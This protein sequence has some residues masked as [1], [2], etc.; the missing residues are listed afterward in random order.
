VRAISNTGQMSMTG[1]QHR[2]RAVVVFATFAFTMIS[3]ALHAQ[4]PTASYG[5]R[6]L[7]T[8][9]GR[10]VGRVVDA[11]TGS[12]IA[13]VTIVLVGG[14]LGTMSGVDGRYVLSSVPAGQVAI[15]AETIGYA[16][17]TITAVEVPA[18]RAVEQNIALEQAAVAL[19]TIEVTAAAER[20]SVTRALDVQRTA[21]NIVSAVTAEQI[22]RSPDGDAAAAMQRVS[23]VTV[24]EGKF[25]FVRGLGERY[26]TTTLNGA[27]VPSPE[28]ERK[29]V[30][31]DLFPTGLL[32]NITTSKTFTPDQPGDFS[33]AQVNIETREFPARR[34]LTLST[35]GGFNSRAT[36]KAVPT[37]PTVGTEW[38]GFAGGA[39]RLPGLVEAAAKFEPVPSQDE[40]NRI[41]D[42]FRNVWTP[43]LSDG[44]ANASLGVSLGGTDPLF[45]RSVSYLASL[46]YARS[47]EVKA[48][49][50]RAQAVPDGLGGVT[51]VNR[52]EGTTGNVGVLWGGLL[53]ASSLLSPSTR[54]VL[55]ATYSRSADNEARTESG[56]SEN[57]AVPLDIM[58]LRFVERNVF[59][60]QLKGEHELARRHRLDWVA[61]V[62]G[63]N[64][65]EPDRSEFVYFRPLDPET[66][67]ELAPEW[68]SASNEGAVRTFG[69]LAENAYEGGANYRID[70]GGEAANHRLR[71]GGLFRYVDRDAESRVYSISANLPADERRRSP[72]EIFD[73]RHT[74]EGNSAMRLTPLFQGGS[75]TAEDVHAAGYGMLELGLS[76]QLRLIGGARFESSTLQ[77]EAVPT[78]GALLR[79]Q[80][81]Y[82]D[83]LP[84]VS[85]NFAFNDQMNLRLS[86]SQTLA[87]PEYREIANIMYREVIGTENVI[88]NPN[89]VRTRI[90]NAD[91]RWEWYPSAGEALSLA[92]FAKDFV[93]PIERVYLA[94]SGT[95]VATFVNAEGATNYGVEAELRKRLGTF[96]EMLEPWTV[97]TNVTLMASDITIGEGA[98]S[99]TNANRS[100]VGQ[101]PY[102]ANAGVT[103]ATA[104]GATSA[105]LLYN[106]V[107]KRIV[108]A[109]EQPL[110]DV[111]ELPRNVLDFSVRM[112]L[113]SALSAKLDLKNLLDEPFEYRQ[114][115]VT[116]ESYR[117][118]R[119]VSLGLSWRR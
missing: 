33:G 20:G 73:G 5:E 82:N 81:T 60:T 91:L 66:N 61:T 95:A 56:F 92:L 109:G 115:S 48:D 11:Q 114:G 94:T 15:R 110:P 44:S 31:L 75:Y 35:G 96:A 113:S 47:Q 19:A 43:S 78:V 63:V 29:T 104:S 9:A 55:N 90:R 45:G 1:H 27:R 26:T 80:T 46:T 50:V 65:N 62:S 70:F 17:K 53:Q 72:E 18:G 2:V 64:R 14:G 23:G 88:G 38:L 12:G 10:I 84:A 37:A 34:Q 22:S 106:V 111:Y 116:R 41:I 99:R 24:Q 103:Y 67:Q 108:T 86:G 39:R 59:S 107:G 58:R 119:L 97:F 69:E 3:G 85:L 117:T 68:L 79:R 83:L 57:F 93:D 54:L 52:Y 74:V 42:T 21:T 40:V 77:L 13:N 51:E 112:G 7:S 6:A 36:G 89:L 4:Q 28:P 8:P 30:P 16:P 100:M 32:Q 118:G 105:T 49:Q 71:F 101:A 87:R 25:V 98:A 102:V 76:K